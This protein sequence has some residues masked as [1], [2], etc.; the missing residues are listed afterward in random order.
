M[1]KSSGGN[2]RMNEVNYT[3]EKNSLILVKLLKE[4]NIKQIII[5]PGST[6]V[7]FAASVQSDSFFKVYSCVDERSAAYMACGLAAE[8]MEPVVI[9]CT[10]ATA[11]RNYLPGLTEAYYRQLPILAVTACQ[12]RERIGH[13]IPQVL[14]RSIEPTDVF[15][16][17]FYI[18]SILNEEKEWAAVTNIN[19]ALIELTRQGGGP[20]HLDLETLYTPGFTTTQL[21]DVRRIDY[22]DRLED[23]P[24]IEGKR[25]A[26]YVG[27][28][29]KWNEA[30]TNAVDLFCEKYN[31]VVLCDQTSNYWGKYRILAN[32]VC[33]QKGYDSEC[34]AM[35]ILLHI[36]Q[37]SGA[38]MVLKPREVWRINKDG[39][40]RDSFKKLTKVFQSDELTF[41]DWY[42]K[43]DVTA[44]TTEYYNAWKDEV[45]LMMKLVPELPF[46]NVWVASVASKQ[47]PECSV[48]HFGIL[49][50][51]RSWNCFEVST[52]TLGYC[53]TGGFGIDGGVSSLI[54]A[55]LANR[56]KIY[57]GVVGDLAF[58]YDMNSIGNRHVGN[59]IRLIVINNGKGNEFRN[60]GMWVSALGAYADDF[61][62]AAGH[63]GNKSSVVIKN[64]AEALGFEYLSARSKD[65]YNSQSLRFWSKEQ[66]DKP[67][68]FEIFTET[69]DESSAL[70][71]MYNLKKSVAGTAKIITKSVLGDKGVSFIKKTFGGKM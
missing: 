20:V 14:D 68:I 28:H 33:M 70:E 24:D 15:K 26:I 51:L 23:Y 10:G 40:V 57:Y 65:E 47:I 25:I 67:M 34:R 48:I 39:E 58:F 19:S 44:C 7:C 1:I 22:F 21:P 64:Y 27:A 52:G 3:S 36:G 61:I 55:S 38:Y 35:D 59:N 31:A 71:I 53:T 43:K 12:P 9:S 13:Y 49:N 29:T 30:L 56:E 8:L 69:E 60:Y 4:H 50:S 37:M 6:N 45:E 17:S 62:C 16:K 11:S 5:S 66:F 2:L 41:F 46:S 54:G 18:E 63:Y 42:N 32:T